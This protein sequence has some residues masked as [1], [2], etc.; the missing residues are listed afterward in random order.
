MIQKYYSD[1]EEVH[2]LLKIVLVGDPA[3]GK[4]SLAKRY[5]DNMFR[6]DY[7]MTIGTDIRTK[8]VLIDDSRIKLV[9]WDLGGQ[10]LFQD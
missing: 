1:P 9:I 2:Y 4:T 5:V 7:I 6:M 3:V 10:P 8:T